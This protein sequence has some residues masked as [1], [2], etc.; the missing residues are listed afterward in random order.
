MSIP[1]SIKRH[2]PTQFG[3]LEIRC[4]GGDKY[5][6]YQI[7]SRWDPEKN[8]P[9]K[10]TG[11]SIGKITEA[12]G[13]IPNANGLRLMQEMRIT[14]DVAPV[15]RNY[16]SYEL[17]QQLSGDLDNQL[18]KYFPDCFREI[19]TIALI[20]LVD[21]VSSTKMI[22]PIFLDSYMSDLCGDI[23]VS[24]GSVRRFI[25]RLGRM[26]DQLDAFMR[27]Q[28]VPGTT[29]LFDGTSIFTRSADSLS[30]K[31]YNPG[32]RLNPQARILYVFEKD[33]HRPVFY[34]VVQGSIVDKTAFV[35]TL[36]AS[37]CKDCIII[38]DKG[39][40][41]KRNLSALMTASMKFILPLQSN[42]VN[43]EDEFY[44]NKDDHKFDGVFTYNKRTV[45]YRKKPSGSKGNFI[46][47]F[48]DDIRKAELQERFVEEAEKHYG[49]A[50]YSPMDVLNDTRMGYFSFC[51]NLDVDAKEIYL[52]Y[53]QRWDIEQCF[54]YLKNS[55][56]SSASHA[57]TDEYFR[58]WAFL[59]HIS[60]IY[61]YGLLNALRDTKLDGKFTAEDVLKLT[62]NIYRVDIGDGEGY[63][64]SAIQKKTRKLLEGL[65][66]DLLRKN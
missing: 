24:E 62:K 53:K 28:V 59:N 29:L 34:R 56:S 27:D 50:E 22:Q 55:V 49:E 61:Y 43:V 13:F 9:R 8:R 31:G 14:P 15:V 37:G 18:R 12:D 19:R 46:Y 33:S 42:T 2:K 65:G 30:E 47:T 48:R 32:H 39:F 64:V 10:V 11:K 5:Y 35:D 21:S 25:S 1:E 3:A 17:L 45:W 6:V 66:V 41:S 58:G 40:Y 57:H 63:K 16:G 44:A 60:L 4:I 52:S 38:A 51:S 36:N 23:A 26:Q 20:R 7:S 54:D